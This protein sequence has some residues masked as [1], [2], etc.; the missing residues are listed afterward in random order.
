MPSSLGES[1]PP[2]LD[3]S[4]QCKKM[5]VGANWRRAQ[6]RACGVSSFGSTRLRRP[7]LLQRSSSRPREP[8]QCLASRRPREPRRRAASGPRRQRARARGRQGRT[9]PPAASHRPWRPLSLSRRIFRLAGAMAPLSRNTSTRSRLGATDTG[10]WTRDADFEARRRHNGAEVCSP[11]AQG[12]RSRGTPHF[13]AGA[14]RARRREVSGGVWWLIAR[15]AAL[16]SGPRTAER[17]P[18]A[19]LALG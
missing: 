4:I 13:R 14:R 15:S 19:D 18:R 1:L 9:K 2:S 12:F 3:F 8:C 5:P 16:P 10:V 11:P 17:A 6:S 7:A